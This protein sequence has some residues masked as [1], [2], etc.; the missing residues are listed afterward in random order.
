[1]NANFHLELIDFFIKLILFLR[2]FLIYINMKRCI[3]HILVRSIRYYD[4]QLGPFVILLEY[5]TK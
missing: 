1:M 4:T 5:I 3:I 2:L